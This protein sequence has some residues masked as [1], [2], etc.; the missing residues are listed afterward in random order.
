MA[1]KVLFG[2]A[3]VRLDKLLLCLKLA[4]QIWNSKLL[5]ILL[6]R[7][8]FLFYKFNIYI[9]FQTLG[10]HWHHLTVIHY[11]LYY[12]TRVHCLFIL[13]CEI[14]NLISQLFLHSAGLYIFCWIKPS[15][16]ELHQILKKIL[17][18]GQS[19]KTFSA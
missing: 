2:T 17:T 5:S 13:L 4:V 19:Y 8:L 18:R 11:N 10:T 9:Y 1:L 7:S 14:C 3:S 16:R 6:S 12:I 15:S